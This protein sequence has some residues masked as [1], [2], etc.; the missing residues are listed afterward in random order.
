M[1]SLVALTRNAE[2]VQGFQLQSQADMVTALGY[3]APGGGIA[4]AGYS[5]Q[6]TQQNSGTAG[7]VVWQMWLN[8]AAANT[9]QIAMVGDWVILENNTLASVC[10]QGNFSSLYTG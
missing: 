6:I 10:K 9:S 3:L 1:S 4:G 2:T 5:G 8:N 7:S